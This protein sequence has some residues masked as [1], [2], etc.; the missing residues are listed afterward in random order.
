MRKILI[1][2]IAAMA[3]ATAQQTRN[4]LPVPSA[5]YN[6]VIGETIAQSRA[7]LSPTPVSAPAN[8]PNILLFMGDD[9]GY[10]MSSTFGGPVPTPNFDRLAALG[11]RYN[12]FHTTALCSPS[13]A[14][15]LT[16][17]NHHKVGVGMLTDLPTDFPGYNTHIPAS[18]STIAQTLKLNGYNT[19]MFG[20]HHNVPPGENTAA[21]PFDMWPTGLGFEYFFGFVAGDSDQWQ[22]HLY[23]G[24]NPLPDPDGRAELL[25]HRLASDAITWIHNQKAAAP[26]KPFFIYYD[27]GSTHA[28]HQAPPE[29]IAR[30]KG[31]FDQGWDKVREQTFER[32]LQIGVIPP[33]TKLTPRPAEIPAWESLTLDQKRFSAGTMEV[34]AAMLA[35]QDDQFGRVLSELDRMGVLDNT[36]VVAI[37]G[38][39]G[40][41]AEVGPRGSVNELGMITNH[42][43]EPD[44]WL[45]A[46]IPKLGNPY[47][48]ESYPAG[49]AWAMDTPYPWT[50]E[51]ASMLGGIRNGLI[52]S[53]KGKLQHPGS[54][55]A[56][57]GHL[58]D[59]AP[60]LLDA[61]HV[62]APDTVYGV[63]QMPY[64]GQS[65]LP[66]LTSCQ[67]EK[68]RTQYF[69]I[70]GK[71]GLY[72]NG[73][74]LSSDDGR[75][76]WEQLPPAGFDPKSPPWSLYDLRADFSQSDDVAA[77]H[78]DRVKDMINTWRKVAQENNV[79][80][81]DHRFAPR[82]T[83][84]QDL[85]KQ[86]DYWGGDIS[87]PANAGPS[88]LGRSFTLKADL[89]IDSSQA[90]GVIFAIGSHFGGW[91]LYLEDGR[92]T[93]TY[94]L[95]T[96]PEDTTRISANNP[97]SA[98]ANS[99]TMTFKSNGVGN[100]ADVQLMKGDAILAIGHVPRTFVS[101]AGGGETLDI[102]RDTGVTVTD[103]RTPHGQLQGDIDRVSLTFK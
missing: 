8:A 82:G 12:R 28:P 35:Y 33:G 92:P 89:N 9:V 4:V 34:A 42:I 64:D 83:N 70:M 81:L 55:C 20:K 87:I 74:F 14:T 96:R 93:F 63:K 101:A 61:A 99:I 72:Q 79:F 26:N 78:P 71:V 59:I 39:N 102:G 98:G 56:E 47:T 40:A 76:P 67:P 50:K 75:K 94:A 3:Q 19:A 36:L 41:S 49:W 11:E 30:F 15:L 32:Q 25:D 66:S 45:I 77:T 10:S 2:G 43:Q 17:R 7:G 86:F 24:T 22:P 52:I 60:T 31:K 90:S 54:I 13:R 80:P 6:G 62:P 65:L 69:E 27:P 37:Q 84:H 29:F 21:G 5:P 1:V 88:F 16:G 100:G 23:R 97:L 103:Y 48:Y 58:V 85:A 73:W 44:S 68:P 57:F 46:N 53:W 38:D 18:A 51:Y 95:S 91:S